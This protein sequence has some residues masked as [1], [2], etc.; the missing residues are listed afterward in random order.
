MKIAGYVRVSTKKQ[1]LEMQIEKIK[2]WA[3][4]HE[5]KVEIYEDVASALDDRPN[6]NKMM[7][8]I[9]DYD[10]IAVVAL[11]RFGR[12]VQ[13][14]SNYF[15]MLEKMEKQLIVLD[16]N[17][18]TTQK[19]GRFLLNVLFAV[20]ELERDIIFERMEAGKQR[21]REEGVKFGRHSLKLPMNTIVEHYKR[22]ASYSWLASTFNTSKTTIYRRLKERGVLDKEAE[23]R[24]RKQRIGP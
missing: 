11:D 22:G 12:S 15:Y 10:G 2:K 6:F 17:I 9:G 4:V 8:R 23:A 14:L 20:A 21:A 3:E 7:E 5:Y 16:Q 24:N 13:Q 18:D 1:S 19:E